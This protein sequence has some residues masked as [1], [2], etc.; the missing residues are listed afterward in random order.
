MWMGLF[1]LDGRGDSA[2]ANRCFG[3]GDIWN[4]LSFR[5]KR[6]EVVAYRHT[7]RGTLILALCLPI[8][9]LVIGISV[10]SGNWLPAIIVAIIMVPLATL[11]SSVELR[12][13]ANDVRRIGTDDPQGLAEALRSRCRG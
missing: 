3:V 1:W 13:G 6:S 4:R 12:V 2:I 5:R 11:F 8:V 7:Q 9:A 10:M